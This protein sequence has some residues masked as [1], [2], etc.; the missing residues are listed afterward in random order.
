MKILI[1]GSTGFIGNALKIFLEHQNISVVPFDIKD[2]PKYDIRDIEML[3]QKVKDANGIIHLAA[4]SRVIT[5]QQEPLTCVST[6]IGGTSNVLESARTTENGTPW[7][8][9]GSSR[10]VFGEPK[11][12]PV[13]EETPKIPINIYGLSKIT[14]ERLCETYSKYYGLKI[15]ILRFSNVYTGIND[16][17]DRV[18]P[19]FILQALKDEDLFI[20]GTGEERFD[21]T[22]IS[23]VIKGIHSCIQEIEGNQSRLNDFNLSIGTPVSL[24]E[25]AELII[26]KT[27][28]KSK[29]MFN[30][31]RDYDVNHFYASPKKAEEQLGF[32]PKISIEE[33]IELTIQELKKI[34]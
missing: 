4:V 16:H 14:G 22:Y 3:E 24:K 25:L 1:T 20:N 28:S 9:F 11:N 21:F 2:D 34:A 5:A 32:K 31:A 23:D 10:E 8:I 17:L 12:F 18:I 7:V 30:E 19:K 15:R 13:T 33:G 26:E 6:N 27:N 29:I